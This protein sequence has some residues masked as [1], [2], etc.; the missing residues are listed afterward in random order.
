MIESSQTC[1]VRS[2]R[3]KRSLRKRKR[4]AEK[5]DRSSREFGQGKEGVLNSGQYSIASID[6]SAQ[7]GKAMLTNR[8]MGALAQFVI[9]T[10]IIGLVLG[11]FG[12]GTAARSVARPVTRG[13]AD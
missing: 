10:F 12:L 13:K 6:F 11:L 3:D 2:A 7:G 8:I 9:T 4:G 1:N 5:N